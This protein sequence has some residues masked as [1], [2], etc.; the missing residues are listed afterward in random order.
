MSSDWKKVHAVEQQEVVLSSTGCTFGHKLTGILID[1]SQI[2]STYW[3]VI[4]ENEI[5]A[6]S[7]D[8]YNLLFKESH[9]AFR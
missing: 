6:S 5:K 3:I 9:E 4:V 8:F 1:T 7:K 2:S